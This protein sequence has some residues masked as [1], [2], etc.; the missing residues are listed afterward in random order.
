VN[1]KAAG[2]GGIP[3]EANKTNV[4]T[5]ADKLL[6]LFEKIWEQEEIPTDLKDRHIIKLPKKDDLTRCEID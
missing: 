6:L 5:T 2:S 1:D 3:A 4:E